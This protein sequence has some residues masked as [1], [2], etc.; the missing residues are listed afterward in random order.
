MVTSLLDCKMGQGVNINE[1]IIKLLT[2]TFDLKISISNVQDLDQVCLIS[3][4]SFKC[5][6]FLS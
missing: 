4:A 2:F 5:D 3:G 1:T 6:F